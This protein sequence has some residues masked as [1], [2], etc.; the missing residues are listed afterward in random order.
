MVFFYKKYKIA[1]TNWP[2]PEGY[3]VY[4]KTFTGQTTILSTGLTKEEAEKELGH[5]N[6]ILN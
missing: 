5:L 3:G 4:F 6:G 2:Y 1:K